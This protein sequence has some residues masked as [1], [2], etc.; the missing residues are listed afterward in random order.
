MTNL[1]TGRDMRW[2]REFSRRRRV[3]IASACERW[4]R[5]QTCGMSIHHG[6]G[7]RGFKIVEDLPDGTK[8]RR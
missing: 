5:G 3:A 7:A 2:W 4:R 8:R 1:P 6:S